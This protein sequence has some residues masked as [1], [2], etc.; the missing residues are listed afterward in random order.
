MNKF[1]IT[2]IKTYMDRQAHYGAVSASPYSMP[3]GVEEVIHTFELTLKPQYGSEETLRKL[4]NVVQAGKTV[5][6]ETT[7][8][9]DF[10][11]PFQREFIEFMEE[12]HP[13]KLIGNQKAWE[14]L[15]NI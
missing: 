12:R 9:A 13:D 7:E 15:H 1:I 6:L 14:A 3:M 8:Y 2:D 10:M 11:R 5:S 4:H